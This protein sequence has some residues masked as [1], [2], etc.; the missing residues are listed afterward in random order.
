MIFSRAPSAR[1]ILRWSDAEPVDVLEVELPLEVDETM[2]MISAIRMA[3]SRYVV[4]PTKS[5]DDCNKAFVWPIISR[6][7]D[8][9]HK[10]SGGITWLSGSESLACDVAA[11]ELSRS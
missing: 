10:I 1:I 6:L 8:R 5:L 7:S 4:L 2:K 9:E 11:G 3:L